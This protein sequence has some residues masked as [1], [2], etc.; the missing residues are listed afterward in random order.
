MPT[1]A[2]AFPRLK[3]RGPIEALPALMSAAFRSLFPRLKDRGPIEALLHPRRD[4]LAAG[5]FPRLKDRGP[6]EAIL[7]LWVTSSSS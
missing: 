4:V 7:A 3:D 6:I 2:A 1:A 5:L